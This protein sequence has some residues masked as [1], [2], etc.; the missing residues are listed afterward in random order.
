MIRLPADGAARRPLV[1]E[2]EG[3]DG[4]LVLELTDRTVTIRPP[5]VRTA[6]AVTRVTWGAL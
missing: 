3:P 5:R 4:P 2:V 6:R 1:R